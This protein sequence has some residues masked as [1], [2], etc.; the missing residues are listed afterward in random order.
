MK[1]FLLIPLVIFVLNFGSCEQVPVYTTPAT[2]IIV[3]HAEKVS[4]EEN[5]P[6]SEVGIKRAQALAAALE[7]A[8]VSAIY[9]SQFDR[10][11]DTARP[12]AER[13]GLQITEIPVNLQ[14]PGDYGKNLAEEIKKKHANRTVLVVG[15]GNTIQATI[16]NLTGE[17]MNLGDIQYTDMFI[18]NARGST[19][20]MKGKVVRAQYGIG[21]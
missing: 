15:H 19:P 12:F 3:R 2:V 4:D 16:E 21:N 17:T 9:T 1:S 11:K 14:N 8:G 20:E 6:L 7:K 10:N 13:A 18:V 5:S